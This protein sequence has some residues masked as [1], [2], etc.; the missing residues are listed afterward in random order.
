LTAFP[1]TLGTLAPGAIATITSLFHIPSNYAGPDPVLNVVTASSATPDPVPA[2]NTGQASASL[3]GRL[4][5]LTVTKDDGTTAVVPGNQVTYTITVSNGGPSDATGVSVR[6]QVTALT[7][8]TW[9]CTAT[10]GGSCTAPSGSGSINTTVNLPANTAATFVL[11]GTVP[12][13]ATGTL[14]K[15]VEAMPPAGLAHPRP[16]HPTGTR[17]PPTAAHPG[18]TT[19]E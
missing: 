15:T 12:P 14:T 7:G 9:T 5:A 18:R 16:G 1:C 19:Q 17:P 3:S 8:A 13:D 11:K 10:G 4:A 6:D 2:N